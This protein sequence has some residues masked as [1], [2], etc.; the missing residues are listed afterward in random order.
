MRA[1]PTAA[2]VN[3]PKPRLLRLPDV[4][5]HVNV[6]RPTLYRMI[7]RREFPQGIKLGARM[8]VWDEAAVLQFVRERIE[9]GA[10]K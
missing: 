5:H 3:D 6:S 4:L 1:E 7:A 2:P 9:Q 10:A 8:T